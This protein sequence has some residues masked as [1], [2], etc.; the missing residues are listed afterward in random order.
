MQ[1]KVVHWYHNRLLHPGHTRT[2]AT[3]GQHFW[4]PKMRDHVRQHVKTCPIC[5]RNKR[6]SKSYGHL[7]PKEAKVIPW[8]K[9]C[10]DLIGPYKIRRKGQKTLVCHACTFID[11]ATGWFEIAQISDKRADTVANVADQE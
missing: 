4:W 8:D 7:P 5:Q 11:P 9:L 6:K 2:E 1:H 3:I 10:I